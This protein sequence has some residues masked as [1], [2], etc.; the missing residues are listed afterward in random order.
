MSRQAG[1]KQK[2]QRRWF[3]FWF[4]T[5]IGS[6]L[7]ILFGDYRLRLPEQLSF[8]LVAGITIGFVSLAALEFVTEK[9]RE[10]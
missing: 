4:L 8:G 6:F 10:E 5:T 9:T 3:R 2:P 7:A 1:I